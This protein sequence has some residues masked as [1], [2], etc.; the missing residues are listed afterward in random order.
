MSPNE[1]RGNR[2]TIV[3]N[4]LA[5]DFEARN[6]DEKRRGLER[7]VEVSRGRRADRADLRSRFPRDEDEDLVD[8]VS[9]F[10]DFAL[11]DD[12]VQAARELMADDPRVTASP[13]HQLGFHWHTFYSATTPEEIEGIVWPAAPDADRDRV[14]AVVDSGIVAPKA[15]PAW[16]G[17]SIVHGADDVEELHEDEVSHGTFV[18]SILRQVAPTHA[19]SMAKAG[20]FEVGA[21]HD[22]EHPMPD[23]TTELHVAG[24]IDRLI[25][26]HRGSCAVEALNL[27][28]GGPSEDDMVMVTMQQAIG[29]W[30]DAFPKSPIFAAAGNSPEAEAIYPAGFRYVR[31]VAAADTQGKQ[32]VWAGDDSTHDPSP[33]QRGW[34][35]DVAPGSGL[36]GLGG[37]NADHT[38]KWSGSS[39]AAA[40]ATASY[41]NGGPVEVAAGLAYWPNRAMRYGDVPG[42]QYA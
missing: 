30:R 31:G 37:R 41:V 19:V 21:E 16:M 18:A 35:D 4:L 11:V 42:L 22:S 36:V 7:A 1:T 24:A 3:P 14:I 28:I 40:V 9:R 15:L 33:P 5:I 8:R 13:V 25:E 12:P 39:F 2:N 38:I 23:P 20:P 34:V 6:A 10:V 27:S 29:R 17:S 32:I 26:R